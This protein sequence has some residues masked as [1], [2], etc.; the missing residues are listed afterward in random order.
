MMVLLVGELVEK[1]EQAA[2]GVTAKRVLR[3]RW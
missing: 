1:A 2:S 3:R